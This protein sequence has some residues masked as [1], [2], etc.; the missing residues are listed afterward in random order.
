MMDSTDQID[1]VRDDFITRMGVVA[2]G[3]GLPRMAGQVFAMLVFEGE[4][5]AFGALSRRL[6]VSRATISTS[7]RLLEERGLIRRVNKTGDRQDYFQLADDAYAAM[8]KYALAGTRHAKSEINDTIRKLPEEAEGVRQRLDTF[9]AFY[10]TI[11]AALD[12]VA[13]R[14][15]K[16]KN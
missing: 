1:Q 14:V 12:D 7:I 9:A 5:I 6:S 10:D 3:E 15:S 16:P 8:T 11:S 13:I 4:P 2:M